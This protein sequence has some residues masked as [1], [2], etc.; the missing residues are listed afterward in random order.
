MD[1]SKIEAMHEGGRFD[2]ATTALLAL[3]G[4]EVFGFM[5]ARL[6]DGEA[7]KEAYSLFAVDV[8]KG[9]PNFRRQCPFRAWAYAIARNAVHRQ[10]ARAARPAR[11]EV[12]M[13]DGASPELVQLVRTSTAEYLRTEV[14][15][16]FA[17]L[18]DKLSEEDQ[19]ILVLRV[20]K[21]MEWRDVAAVLLGP[22][23][24]AVELDRE[25]ARLRQGF[26]AL[27]K[28]LKTLARDEGLIPDDE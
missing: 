21:R 10:A 12:A 27:K 20:D 9:M 6:R 24:P 22:D 3:Y 16:R 18:R 28:R 17:E 25:A 14:K 23:A 5:R 1:E 8:W 11:R 15:S 26:F 4:R 2:E 7:A 19:T 13:G